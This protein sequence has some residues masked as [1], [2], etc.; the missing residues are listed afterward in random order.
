MSIA[1]AH[2]RFRLKVR[3]VL[4]K[5]GVDNE[6]LTVLHHLPKLATW[7]RTHLSPTTPR[8]NHR[9]RMYDHLQ[10]AVLGDEPIDYLEFG[11]YK[12]E[13]M[14]YWTGIHA[15]PDS[16]FIGFDSF[17]GLP[18]DWRYF[19]GT[20]ESSTFDAG[21]VVPDVDDQRAEFVKGL[22]QDS[23]PG[24]LEAFEPRSRIVL[25]CDAD[26]YSS[27]LY[28]LTQCDHLLVPG[29]VV[30]FDEF[31]AVMDEFAAL[32]DYCKAYRREYDVVACTEKLAHL[33]IVMR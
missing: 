20:I 33:A 3:E 32:R 30:I 8:F 10:A 14:S 17:E 29:S 2:Y 6:R 11:V 13:S 31:C 15:H 28:A 24:F 16:R 22:F 9:F 26:L 5:Y 7:E 21:G 25:H 4:T 19:G 1:A 18:E 12:G 23:L 27:T